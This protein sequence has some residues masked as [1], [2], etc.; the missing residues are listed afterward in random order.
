[1]KNDSKITLREDEKEYLE[2]IIRSK[3]I[4][5]RVVQ[6]AMILLLREKGESIITIAN[7]VG[8]TKKSVLYCLKVYE[9]GG[10]QNALNDAHKRGRIG[11]FS[12]EEK[13][14]VINTVNQRPINVGCPAEIWTFT[15]L[16]EYLNEKAEEAGYARLSTISRTSVVNILKQVGIKPKK[17][18]YPEHLH[19]QYLD[20]SSYYH[21]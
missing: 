21:R 14:W 15:L 2:T 10:A 20:A 8:L 17:I 18:R 12:D 16:T 3:T 11:D 19:R 5:L 13:A 6:R 1:M 9:N 4:P 7:K